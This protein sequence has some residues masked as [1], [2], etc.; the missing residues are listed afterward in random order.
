MTT[1]FPI[2]GYALMLI[3]MHFYN[4]TGDSHRKMI[5]DI[6]ARRSAAGEAAAEA[7]EEAEE[8][9]ESK[10]AETENAVENETEEKSEEQED[11]DTV[12]KA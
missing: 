2:I 6:M 4:I 3:P 9:E 11:K 5:K 1:V 7:F 10:E 12:K 8:I